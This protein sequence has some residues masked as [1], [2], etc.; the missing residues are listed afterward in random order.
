[1]QRI[2]RP[3]DVGVATARIN[4]NTRFFSGNYIAIFLMLALYS[5]LT[6]PLLLIAIG[7]L[8]GVSTVLLIN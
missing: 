7:F 8:G 2:S 6:N 3:S 5:L 1:M 4:Y